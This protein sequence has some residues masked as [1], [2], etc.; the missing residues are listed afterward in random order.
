MF[1]DGTTRRSI[2]L[3]ITPVS[4]QRPTCVACCD[5]VAPL[6]EDVLPRAP[7]APHPCPLPLTYNTV[8]KPKYYSQTDQSTHIIRHPKIPESLCDGC[9]RVTLGSLHVASALGN[10][11]KYKGSRE[12]WQIVST[13]ALCTPSSGLVCGAFCFWSR[14]WTEFAIAEYDRKVGNSTRCLSFQ[15]ACL[16]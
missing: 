7:C 14:P 5:K 8:A 16:W 11:E 6:P 9:T 10:K 1:V 12:I 4:G 15:R 13:P 3:G 2:A